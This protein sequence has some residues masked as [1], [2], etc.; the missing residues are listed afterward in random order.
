MAV[1][2]SKRMRSRLSGLGLLVGLLVGLLSSCA[3]A[4]RRFPLA[5]PLW[6]DSDQGALKN[7]PGK[8]Y[9][10]MIADVA[11]KILFRPVARLF[12]FPLSSDAANVNAIDEVPNSSWFTN[13]IG[14]FSMSTAE[15][16]QGSCTDKGL[17]PNVGPW[18]VVGAKPDGAN[19]G[20]FIK[21]KSGTYLLKFDGPMQPKRATAADVIG[22]RIYHAA[23]YNAPCNRVVYFRKSILK[24]GKG[25]KST[26]AYGEKTP[27][28]QK[29]VDQ[30]LA[31]AFRKKNGIM[32][33]AA[34]RFLPG[35][36][37][38]PFRYNNRRSDDKNDVI[39]HENRRELRGAR[40]LAA[41][42][43]HFDA[44][45][46]NTLDLLVKREGRQFIKHYYI[47]FGDCFGSR[48]DWDGISRRLGHSYYF[49]AEHVAVDLVSLGLVKRPWHRAKIN[50]DA[51]IFGYYS[52]DLF[53]PSKWQAAYP[54]PAFDAMNFRDAL[55]MVRI[56]SRFTDEHIKA[57]I[58]E[59]QIDDPRAEAYLLKTLI[60][61]RDMIV[62]EYLRKYAPLDRFRLVR[63]KAK[64]RT[65]SLC[66][67]D[68]AVKHRLVPPKDVLYKMRFFA[69]K[70]WDR[71]LGW[72]Q[73][74]PDA[75][76]PHRSCVVMP[77]GDKRPA[78]LA[79]KGAAD[80][81]ALRYGVLKIFIH[82]RPTLPPTSSIWLHLY[83]LGPQRG[84][85]LVGIERQPK[86]KM[87]DLY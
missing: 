30:V 4:P 12:Y 49:D 65:Q 34:S 80:D 55:W 77:I 23:G 87:P 66:F 37:L 42:V 29:E 50:K 69:G 53:V 36:P 71:Q 56:I 73:F 75:E 6:Q 8:Y 62:G 67:E 78:D 33:A 41:W 52:S 76:H 72:L 85:R 20:F 48:W 26:N 15:V 17:D 59:G 14:L 7:K 5:P 38:G 27:L 47:D 60:K 81:H 54:N 24:I 22:S 40:L 58:K 57:M 18:L 39:R 51:E 43:N 83:D 11:D 84:Y 44:R 3:T 46:Q 82:Q 25:A 68:T 86:P 61:R 16:A 79:P 28:T 64:Q 2:Q 31:M 1:M 19:P 70:N 10:G 45:E 9:S 13:R 35:K 21:A 63:R 32:R 74:S